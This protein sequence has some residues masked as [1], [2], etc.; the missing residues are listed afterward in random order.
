MAWKERTFFYYVYTQAHTVVSGFTRGSAANKNT[1]T[2]S[3]SLPESSL[4]TLS[5]SLRT[6]SDSRF[7]N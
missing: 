1:H 6:E 2:Q 7:G 4:G 3:Q 5:E